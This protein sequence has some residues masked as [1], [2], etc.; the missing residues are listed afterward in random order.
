MFMAK[1]ISTPH[2]YTLYILPP[3]MSQQYTDI[4][5]RLIQQSRRSHLT[6]SLY[7]YDD[8]S[9]REITRECRYL[10][11]QINDTVERLTNEA[12]QSLMESDKPTLA[13]LTILNLCAQRN[14]RCL[15]GYHHH[16]LNKLRDLYWKSG[17]ALAHLLNEHDNGGIRDELS[18]TEVDFLRGYSSLI[19][20][21]KSPFLDVVDITSGSLEPPKDLHI[22]V[23]VVRDAGLIETQGG[24]VDFRVGQRFMV[25]R[26]DVERLLVQG[27]L[28]QVD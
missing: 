25:R 3:S 11:S 14:K 18:P 1:R 20:Q 23:R 10:N 27:Y 17:A 16:R 7:A 19:T 4:A 22:S 8:A 26:S 12:D 6:D 9:V 28:E 24:P 5:H 15:L 13:Q 2:T 21:Y